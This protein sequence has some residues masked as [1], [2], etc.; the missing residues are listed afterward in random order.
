[1]K[2][3]LREF[4]YHLH[5]EA[6]NSVIILFSLHLFTQPPN[7]SKLA[8]K[9]LI[10]RTIYKNPNANALMGALMHYVSRMVEVPPTMFGITGGSS[11]VF[12]IADTLMSLF[13]F[14]KSNT[15]FLSA[16]GDLPTTFKMHYPLANQ[17]LLLVLILTNHCSMKTNPY[18][19]SLFGCADSQGILCNLI[20]Y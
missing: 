7:A 15:D 13:T 2:L 3:R 4:T 20:K 19:L 6:V 1:M 9:S 11:F 18:R 10:Y 16:G 14:R 5:L 8:D 12:G 17:S